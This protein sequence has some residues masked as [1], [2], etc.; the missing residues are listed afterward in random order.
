ML[1]DT[2]FSLAGCSNQ[3]LTQAESTHTRFMQRITDRVFD[4]ISISFGQV[5]C[6]PRKLLYISQVAKP[7]YSLETLKLQI[8]FRSRCT[9]P[10]LVTILWFMFAVSWTS[11]SVQRYSFPPNISPEN[12]LHRPSLISISRFLS[13][14]FHVLRISVPLHQAITRAH[15]SRSSPLETGALIFAPLKNVN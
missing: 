9:S 3:E 13:Y 10:P 8:T 2:P 12:S 7:M 5:L 15:G 11:L 4:S 1:L 14:T 6:I